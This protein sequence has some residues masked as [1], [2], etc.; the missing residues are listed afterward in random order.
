MQGSSMCPPPQQLALP[1]I[2]RKEA[3]SAKLSSLAQDKFQWGQLINCSPALAAL[4]GR[5]GTPRSTHQCLPSLDLTL[6]LL[7]FPQMTDL[8][9]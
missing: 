9:D 2:P 7:V 4:T 6:D 3:A 5:T 8:T 1:L